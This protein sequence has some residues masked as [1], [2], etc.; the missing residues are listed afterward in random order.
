M[1]AIPTTEDL[2]QPLRTGLA[3]VVPLTVVR[4]EEAWEPAPV[5]AWLAFCE[6]DRPEHPAAAV[7]QLPS[8][9]PVI[10]GHFASA[11]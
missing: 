5:E 11:R 1:S 10:R 3:P 9:K 8:Q 6:G 2:V 7:P 4:T